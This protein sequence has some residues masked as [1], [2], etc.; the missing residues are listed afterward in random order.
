MK[1]F[2]I[3]IFLELL[4]LTSFG[5]CDSS[6]VGKWKVISCFNGEVYFNLKN[7]ST[8]LAP[9]IK[10][11]YPDTLSQKTF[12][13]LAKETYGSFVYDFEKDGKF[14]FFLHSRFQFSGQYCFIKSKHILRQ[15]TKNSLGE[16]VTEDVKGKI[17]NGLLYISQKWED[18]T[19]Y[20]IVLERVKQ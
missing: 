16:D 18:N 19:M 17:E 2:I 10:V 3:F 11:I 5:Q 20:N 9:E 14:S 13:E 7:D 15:T 8:F 12:I 1:Y 6:L 4:K